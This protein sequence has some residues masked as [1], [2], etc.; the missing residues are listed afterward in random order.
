MVMRR[1]TSAYYR[2]D[3]EKRAGARPDYIENIEEFVVG[4]E[5]DEL[6]LRVGGDPQLGRLDGDDGVVASVED[7]SGLG[8]TGVFLMTL[9]VVEE[10]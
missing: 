2:S 8:T 7:E 9:S 10:V 6:S 4:I 5:R 1:S 3:F